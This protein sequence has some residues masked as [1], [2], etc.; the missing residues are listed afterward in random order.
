MK[1]VLYTLAAFLCLS[2]VS[3]GQN[4][5]LNGALQSQALNTYLK[6][7]QMGLSDAEIKNQLA[8]RG[9][10]ASVFEQVKQA[11]LKQSTASAKRG[12]FKSDTSFTIA[13][14][15]RDTSWVFKKPLEVKAKLPYFG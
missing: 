9:Y 15:R 2:F 6:A 1:L 11:G 14:P 12:E 10:P 3:N 4:V 13:T 5:K 7:K 8:K